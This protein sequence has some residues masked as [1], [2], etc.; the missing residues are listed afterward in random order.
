VASF[1]KSGDFLPY[2]P[3]YYRA[4]R[5]RILAQRRERWKN[6]PEF[7]QKN[8]ERVRAR[9]EPDRTKY[10]ADYYADRREEKKSNVLE[11]YREHLDAI[12]AARREKYAN[13]PAFREKEK[14]RSAA[15]RAKKKQAPSE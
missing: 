1:R 13:D 10:Q 2:N 9:D 8:A 14:Q 4:N 12:N 7:R 6:D 5:E 3:E 15:Q 11:N